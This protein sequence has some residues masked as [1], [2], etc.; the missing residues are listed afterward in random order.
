MNNSRSYWAEELE[1]YKVLG[2]TAKIKNFSYLLLTYTEEY[3]E[4][5]EKFY[6]QLPSNGD[7]TL[8]VLKGHLLIE[9]QIRSY[10]YNHFPN[11]KVL[12][13]VFKDTHSLISAGKAYADPS[14][15]DTIA[16]W[17]CF[18]KLNS[19]RNF[20]AHRLD[21]TGLL[22]K[23]EDFLKVSEPFIEFGPDSDSVHDRMHNA[24]NAIYQK[25]LYL[26]TLQEQ[27]YRTFEEQRT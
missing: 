20:L 27:K 6:D 25:A 9:Q 19:I 14:C 15:L 11:Q 7:L 8:L 22:H 1:K 17:D 5:L 16:L 23:I 2:D 4:N 3:F 21:Q 18:I 12:K 13:D 24:I 26:S 10:V